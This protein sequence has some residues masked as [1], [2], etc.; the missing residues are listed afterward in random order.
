MTTT[1][2]LRRRPAAHRIEFA[3][4]TAP[5]LERARRSYEDHYA[6]SCALKE[7]KSELLLSYD[8]AGMNRAVAICHWGRSGSL[9]LAS[10]L[11]GHPDLVM[12]PHGTGESIYPFLLEHPSLSLWE[13]LIAYPAYSA[14]RTEAFGDLFR[15]DN[16]QADFAI[17]AADY[18]AAVLALFEAF[19]ARSSEWLAGRARF[20]QL[21]HVAYTVAIG[22]RLANP[23]PL[24]IYAQHWF[25]Q[26]LARH[27]VEDF[28]GAQFLHTIRDPISAID[29]WFEYRIGWERLRMS[30]R[31]PKLR[32]IDPAVWA[33]LEMLARG[34]DRSHRGMEARTRAVRFEDMHLAPEATM[35]RVAEWVGIPYEPC[36]LQS[37]WNGNPYVVTIRGISWCGA[38]PANA[39]RRSK[40][41]RL[42]DR[43]L[44]F[45]LMREH[46]S[47]WR[48]PIPRAFRHRWVRL[49]V[50]ASLW[51]LPMRM[52]L[53]AARLV[54]AWQVLPSVRRGRLGF[55]LGAPF[56][57]LQRRLRMMWLIAGQARSRLK[58]GQ[59]ILEP[60]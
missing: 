53:K 37:T 28:P 55:A 51:L 6:A 14:A 35:R 39:Q 56:F 9:L 57:L 43:L 49:W 17:D 3:D 30:S 45:A 36:L 25:N 1:A 5:V 23:R 22:R 58:G 11:D 59:R 40:N 60:L 16:P 2:P 44:I 50:I 32:Y 54:L 46:F 48:Y 7:S 13:K 18:Y 10:Y 24:M 26:T 21:L 31:D 52:E 8:V 47:A 27:F 12:L 29:S 4:D 19:G 15:K 34:W 33:S 41:L 42:T 20:F 38:N